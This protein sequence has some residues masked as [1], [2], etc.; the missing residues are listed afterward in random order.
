M[1]DEIRVATCRVARDASGWLVET[2][3]ITTI[4][5]YN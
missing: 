2:V 5:N 1:K 4:I 3:W